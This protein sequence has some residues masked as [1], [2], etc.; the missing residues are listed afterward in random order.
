VRRLAALLSPAPIVVL[1]LMIAASAVQTSCGG[2]EDPGSGEDAVIA[3]TPDA[4]ADAQTTDASDDSP[5]DLADGMRYGD[6]Y[7]P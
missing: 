2:T 5:G 4:A 7:G 6:A 1:G 3:S